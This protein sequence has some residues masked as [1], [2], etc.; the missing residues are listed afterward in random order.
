M[1]Q[2]ELVQQSAGSAKKQQETECS[3]TMVEYNVV[4]VVV[5]GWY[6]QCMQLFRLGEPPFAKAQSFKG[7]RVRILPFNIHPAAC[8]VENITLQASHAKINKT[9]LLPLCLQGSYHPKNAANKKRVVCFGLSLALCWQ[10][11]W[12][13]C[14]ANPLTS[15]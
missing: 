10:A 4:V 9:D 8:I 6:N 2:V 12:V 14:C 5:L 1:K 11:S 3:G 7:F 13:L 15:R